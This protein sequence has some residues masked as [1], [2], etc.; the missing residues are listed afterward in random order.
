MHFQDMLWLAVVMLV[1]VM[2]PAAWAIDMHDA[3]I[4]EI[5][6]LT[7]DSVYPLV[8]TGSE[9]ELMRGYCND[10]IPEPMAEIAM[11]L[12]TTAAPSHT[13]TNVQVA[14]VDES[15]YIK[16]DGSVI[17]VLRDGVL[18]LVDTD[19]TTTS[20]MYPDTGDSYH[21][22][23]MN[24][25]TFYLMG[26]D[27]VA[28][29]DGNSTR[30]IDT[31]SITHA[32]MIDD[33]VYTVSSGNLCWMPL[34]ESAM[35]LPGWR[36]YS[37]FMTTLTA[38]NND[39]V[40]QRHYLMNAGGV[41]Y[42]SKTAMYIAEPGP[43]WNITLVH[44]ISVDTLQYTGTTLVPGWLVNQ[45]ALDE[46]NGMLR[47][48][49]TTAAAN[50]VFVYDAGTMSL[51]HELDG[52]APGESITSARFAGDIAY[53]VTFE[54][55]DPFFVVDMS[56]RPVV[57]GEL[58][59]PGFST[60]LH[61]YGDFV[62]GVGVDGDEFG[63][64]WGAKVALFDVSDLTNPLLASNHTYSGSLP[65]DHKAFMMDYNLISVPVQTAAATT[66]KFLQVED[67]AL[68]EVATHTHDPDGLEPRT[69]RIGDTYYTVAGD[70]MVHDQNVTSLGPT[71]LLLYSD[72][73]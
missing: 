9:L 8:V 27:T 60:Y 73:Q 59:L 10:F 18:H 17:A 69:F 1:S 52:I 70:T 49:T 19:G 2:A 47:V 25:N 64:V 24:N 31:G 43:G 71:G 35:L 20:I 53:L 48:A 55:V 33:T 3:A 28:I 22:L 37:I 39:G 38:I 40:T 67:G 21:S 32:R 36:D 63:N 58:K 72:W 61:P 62:I 11:D 34:P 16:T 44:R 68:V 6:G 56:D 30:T 23:F 50:G 66:F 5:T 57:L 45:F 12:A 65:Q 29:L 41:V 14:G 46:Y 42:V 26:D 51:V 15:D 4:S 13:S 7:A 54:R